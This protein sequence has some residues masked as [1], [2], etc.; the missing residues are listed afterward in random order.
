MNRETIDV[1]YY[2]P[3]SQ[4]FGYD[5]FRQMQPFFDEDQWSSD[6]SASYGDLLDLTMTD[7]NG[8]AIISAE[9]SML[10]FDEQVETLG[11]ALTTVLPQGTDSVLFLIGL[12][13]YVWLDEEAFPFISHVALGE[14]VIGFFERRQEQLVEDTVKILCIAS[15]KEKELTAEEDSHE[16]FSHMNLAEMEYSCPPVLSWSTVVPHAHTNEYDESWS[17]RRMERNKRSTWRMRS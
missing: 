13:Q 1:K 15:L 2:P 6:G 14:S 10:E 7:F 12:P 11:E 9:I 17:E 5:A 4:L 8:T 16:V 3:H